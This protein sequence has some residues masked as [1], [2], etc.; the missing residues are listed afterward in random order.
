ML[1]KIIYGP[2]DGDL[3]QYVGV[4]VLKWNKIVGNTDK[5]E[6]AFR[7][8]TKKEIEETLNN[9]DYPE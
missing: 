5:P 7:E 8:A 3:V 1:F 4:Y 9:E 6:V 2:K